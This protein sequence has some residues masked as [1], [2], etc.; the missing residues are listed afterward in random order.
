[1]GKVILLLSFQFLWEYVNSDYFNGCFPCYQKVNGSLYFLPGF[2][3]SRIFSRTY[4]QLY[5]TGTYFINHEI[6]SGYT[7]WRTR[8]ISIT[9]I[10]G[11]ELTFY[12]LK[13]NESVSVYLVESSDLFSATILR[14]KMSPQYIEKL[15][16]RYMPSLSRGHNFKKVRHLGYS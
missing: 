1:M 3:L 13:P 16:H 4:K 15:L 6:P 14:S 7:S 2:K 10:S 12:H 11:G 8:T 9:Q 5:Y